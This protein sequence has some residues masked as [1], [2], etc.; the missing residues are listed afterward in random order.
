MPWLKTKLAAPAAKLALPARKVDAQLFK[1]VSRLPKGLRDW[2]QAE[3][4]KRWVAFLLAV[5][6]LVSIV[7]VAGV[8]EWKYALAAYVGAGVLVLLSQFSEYLKSFVIVVGAIVGPWLSVVSFNFVFHCPLR[9]L[10]LGLWTGLILAGIVFALVAYAYVRVWKEDAIPA[11]I[12]A[13]VL[14]GV[15]VLGVPLLL[16]STKA[17]DK[18]PEAGSGD[19]VSRLDVAIIVPRGTPRELVRVDG[20]KTQ[21]GWDVRWSVGRDGD[22]AVDWLLL[23]CT[24]PDAAL[25]AARG[26]GA[27][28]TAKP[29]WR[30]KTD[31]VVVLAV[32]ATPPVFSKPESLPSIAESD[33]EITRWLKIAA[34]AAPGAQIAVLLQTKD[35]TRLDAWSTKVEAR[36]GSVESLQDLGR[37]SLTDAAQVMAVQAP[38]AKQHLALAIQYR[39]VLLFDANEKQRSPLDVD[40]FFA[41]GRVGLC[42]DDSLKREPCAT[43]SSAAQLESGPTHL[44]IGPPGESTRPVGSAILRAS[45]R[46]DRAEAAVPGLLVVPGREPREHRQRC[47]PRSRARHPRQDLLRPSLGLGGPGCR[48]RRVKQGSTPP[49]CPLRPAQARRALQ[50]V[51]GAGAV[52]D[53]ASQA[54]RRPQPRGAQALERHPRELGGDP[55]RRRPPAGIRRPGHALHVF[56]ALHRRVPSGCRERHGERLRRRAVVER[57]RHRDLRDD[58]IHVRA[59][60]P[61]ESARQAGGAVER[62]HRGLGAPR[63]HPERDVLHG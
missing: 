37:T 21:A 2:L 52:G 33:G 60:V 29:T 54:A 43:I 4:K 11:G 45:D 48:P 58:R 3:W 50:L 35:Q 62:V 31:R 56:M 47:D 40:D 6:V 36:G 55:G 12:V 38:R 46:G 7:P 53:P 27:A 57:K 63:L 42:Q 22:A 14:A 49:R 23:D 44:A 41:S 26:S 20:A 1:L 8:I 25:T 19:V 24:D 39:P 51:G 59:A 61:H 34:E 5:A 30:P 32:D 9:W 17:P 16:G 15:N 18:P 10:G 13:V 28:L